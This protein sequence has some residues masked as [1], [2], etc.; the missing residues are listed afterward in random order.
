M[1]F[2]SNRK[3]SAR[4]M[5][6]R[7]W[8]VVGIAAAVVAMLVGFGGR[9]LV[10]GLLSATPYC[11]NEV[12]QYA[13]PA[14]SQYGNTQYGP[15]TCGPYV[16]AFSPRSGSAGDL[17]KITGNG[18]T[19]VTGVRFGDVSASFVV[20]DEKQ[21]LATVPSAAVTG[22][23][24]VTVPAGSLRS[25][26]AFAV[27]PRVDSVTPAAAA[28]GESV[29]IHGAGLVDAVSVEFGKIGTRFNVDG[30]TQVTATVPAGSM[31]SAL[32]VITP[33]G[34]AKGAAF[35]VSPRL[36]SFQPVAGP[37][38]TV[39]TISGSGL[40]S[41]TRVFFNGVEVRFKRLSVVALS[42]VVPVGATTGPIEVSS[43]GGDAA[44]V[45]DYTVS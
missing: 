8:V 35:L 45:T 37:A 22:P 28:W 14:S 4:H 42:A 5:S 19:G 36:T 33:F 38:G 11:P 10:A 7:K 23:V 32:S 20:L 17:V 43:P 12:G 44:T 16:K 40:G 18:F 30:P 13:A 31:D 26:L 24:V 34:K 25:A 3:G 41:V 1:R 6:A 21:I 9:D 2:Q 27:S 15:S 39:V 29:V